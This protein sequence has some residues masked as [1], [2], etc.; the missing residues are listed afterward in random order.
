MCRSIE[1]R[2]ENSNSRVLHLAQLNQYQSYEKSQQ[3]VEMNRKYKAG[4]HSYKAPSSCSERRAS[5]QLPYGIKGLAGTKSQQLDNSS[6]IHALFAACHLN[7]ALDD[8]MGP[9]L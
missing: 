7:H 8:I 2:T 4:S 6:T 5:S 9:Q 1:E 3:T